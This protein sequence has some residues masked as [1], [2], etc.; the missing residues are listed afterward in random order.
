LIWFG[1]EPNLVWFQG[2]GD[3]AVT[4]AAVERAVVARA[5]ETHC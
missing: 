2:T 1:K 5:R 4:R 3:E